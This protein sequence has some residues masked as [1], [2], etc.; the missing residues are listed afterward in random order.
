MTGYSTDNI[1]GADSVNYENGETPM[2]DFQ[3]KG[4]IA[5]VYQIVKANFEAGKS[6]EEILK[7]IASLE[8]GTATD[9]A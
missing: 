5:M 6:P 4:I 3:Y 2:T 8:K 7:I 9:D 1:N